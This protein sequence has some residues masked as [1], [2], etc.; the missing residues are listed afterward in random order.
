[1]SELAGI[2]ERLRRDSINSVGQ[3]WDTAYEAADK[4]EDLRAMLK[5][6]VLQIEYLHEK[7]GETGS[8]NAVLARARNLLT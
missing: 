7:F 3:P 6:A 5:E 4:I 8:G 2:V 1:M